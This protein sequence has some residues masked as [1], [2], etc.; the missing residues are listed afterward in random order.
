MKPSQNFRVFVCL[1]ISL[2]NIREKGAKRN[3]KG[4]ERGPELI[5]EDHLVEKRRM[6]IGAKG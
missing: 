5:G 1:L 4:G 3:C 6:G 2:K